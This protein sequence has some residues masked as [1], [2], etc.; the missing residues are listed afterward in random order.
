MRKSIGYDH[1]TAKERGVSNKTVEQ[2]TA[3]TDT[4][5]T[6]PVVPSIRLPFLA[7]P[8]T[9]TLSQKMMTTTKHWKKS[10]KTT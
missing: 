6:N 3:S 8:P 10:S 9:D 7:P 4:I 2:T 5:D 1:K